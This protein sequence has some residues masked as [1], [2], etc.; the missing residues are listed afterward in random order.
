MFPIVVYN[1]CIRIV[2]VVPE[3]SPSKGV[4]PQPQGTVGSGFQSWIVLSWC[5]IDWNTQWTTQWKT[6]KRRSMMRNWSRYEKVYMF[7]FIFK[8]LRNSSLQ[9]LVFGR[10]V[11]IYLLDFWWFLCHHYSWSISEDVTSRFLKVGLFLS[12]WSKGSQYLEQ[13]AQLFLIIAGAIFGPSYKIPAILFDWTSKVN[14]IMNLE[15]GIGNRR[16]IFFGS[17]V[18]SISGG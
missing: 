4:L 5:Y 9:L 16:F 8:I 2:F 13:K 17:T 3:I 10:R 18:S 6:M 1:I 15:C 7:T 14:K 12:W 11:F